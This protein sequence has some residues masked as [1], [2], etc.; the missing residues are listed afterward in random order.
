[1]KTVSPSGSLDPA[2]YL[3]A[4]VED[5]P[6]DHFAEAVCPNCGTVNPVCPNCYHSVEASGCQPDR[7]ATYRRVMAMLAEDKH[8][9]A[10]F[11]DC[12]FLATGDAV[13]D[14]QTEETIAKLHK[15]PVAQVEAMR[16]RIA[17]EL[18][19]APCRKR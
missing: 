4:S 6:A 3:Q 5:H 16:D 15:V 19:I 10:F 17:R 12:F 11:I 18:G 8:R 2:E 9:G 7:A 14:G 13:F 1:M